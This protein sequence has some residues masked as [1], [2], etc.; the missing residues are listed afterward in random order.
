MAC[1]A[2]TSALISRPNRVLRSNAGLAGIVDESN[3]KSSPALKVLSLALVSSD[4]HP[5]TE[6]KNT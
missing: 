6:R 2:A 4:Q 3:I 5:L 1:R